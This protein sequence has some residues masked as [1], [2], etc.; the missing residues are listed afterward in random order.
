[1]NGLSIG[2]RPRNIG[3]IWSPGPDGVA[4]HQT[5][6][7]PNGLS[8]FEF[9]FSP[10]FN[11][12]ALLYWWDVGSP[13]SAFTSIYPD[14]FDDDDNDNIHPLIDNGVP[15]LYNPG[16]LPAYAHDVPNDWQ[17]FIG[18]ESDKETAVAIAQELNHLS[19]S[20]F[21]GN[22]K[23]LSS[24]FFVCIDGFEWEMYARDPDLIERVRAP[25][26]RSGKYRL[27]DLTL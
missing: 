5:Q 27:K 9:F 14:D 6:G 2:Y 21:L 8:E 23:K 16:I 3:Y 7:V 19:E 15:G 20:G 12:M 13:S 22:V 1:M 26:V 17:T 25:L 18:I 11:A 4:A 10:I 24:L